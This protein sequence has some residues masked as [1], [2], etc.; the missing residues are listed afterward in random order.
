MDPSVY[1]RSIQCTHQSTNKHMPLLRR[2]IGCGSPA[3]GSHRNSRNNWNPTPIIRQYLPKGTDLSIYSQEQ[4]DAIAEEINNRP[5]KG[6]G[7]RSPLAVYRELVVN[8]PPS[9]TEIQGVALHSG[10]RPLMNLSPTNYCQPTAL[11]TNLV[12]Q[13]GPVA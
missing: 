9:F 11:Q 13:C 2:L 5:R 6:L 10:I 7:A 4:V 12:G 1:V 3:L 8:S